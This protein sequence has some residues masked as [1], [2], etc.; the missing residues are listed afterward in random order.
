MLLS[1]LI[2]TANCESRRDAGDLRHAPGFRES[3]YQNQKRYNPSQTRH[4]EKENIFSVRLNLS[5]VIIE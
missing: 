2:R 4:P 5:E 1:V 3:K